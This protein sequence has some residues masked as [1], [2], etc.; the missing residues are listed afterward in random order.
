MKPLPVVAIDARMWGTTHAGIGRYIEGLVSHLSSNY[1]YVLLVDPHNQ[2]SAAQVPKDTTLI[3]APWRHYSLEEQRE[4][5]RLLNKVKPDLFHVPHFNV[6][7]LYQGKTVVTIHD[8]LWHRKKGLDV[9]TLHPLKYLA[10]YLG[11][12]VV[13]WRAVTHSAAV[14]VPS[15]AVLAEI[16]TFFPRIEP[17]KCQ[18][19]YEGVANSLLEAKVAAVPNLPT[20]YLFHLGSLY[21]HKRVESSFKVLEA[22]EGLHL[23]LASSRNEFSEKLH[24]LAHKKGI[25][26]RVHF[27]YSLPDSQVIYLMSKALALIVPSESE[28]FGLPGIE[29]MKLGC[30]VIASRTP[31]AEEIYGHGALF[32]DPMDLSSWLD[33]LKTLSSS[34][35]KEFLIRT[36]AREVE[37][38]QF[39]TMA[40]ETEAVYKKVLGP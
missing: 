5:P 31:A 13:V 6:P 10:K 32:I 24:Q 18:V 8:L 34:Q 29:A 9:T 15:H 39:S 2:P 37:R 40:S 36:A 21:P 11:Y 27:L 25:D 16:A 20:R 14:I 28:G 4:L 33:A 30:P 23:V 3:S 12:R 26:K 17:S 38:Y 22:D 35:K 7:I 19:I 1:R